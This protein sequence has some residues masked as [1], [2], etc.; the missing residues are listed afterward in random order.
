VFHESTTPLDYH[1]T[2]VIITMIAVELS[3]GVVISKD[4]KFMNDGYLNDG[5]LNDGYSLS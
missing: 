2:T 4:Q 3:V 1:I 5:Y